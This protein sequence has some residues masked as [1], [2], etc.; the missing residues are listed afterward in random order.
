MPCC[1]KRHHEGSAHDH[2]SSCCSSKKREAPAPKPTIHKSM[3]IQNILDLFPMQAEALKKEISA[4]GLH[5]IGCQAAVWETL[6]GGMVTH[7]KTEGEVDALVSRLNALLQKK[8]DSSTISLTARAAAKFLDISTQENQLGTAIRFAAE[9]G[10]CGTLDYVLDFSEA[11]GENDAVFISHGIEIHALTTQ[12]AQL[13][14]CEI[15]FVDD[16]TGTGFKITNPNVR[17]SCGCRH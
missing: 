5:C 2:P 16:P 1:S 15:D 4:A 9:V 3:T 8:S 14:G 10:G 17:P 11:A 7:G 6:E 13:L 12:I